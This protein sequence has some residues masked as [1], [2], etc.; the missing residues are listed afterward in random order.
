[1][2]KVDFAKFLQQFL[3]AFLESN[4]SLLNSPTFAVMLTKFID[5]LRFY[6]FLLDCDR[7]NSTSQ[8]IISEDTS[9]AP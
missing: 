9:K 4:F 6:H 3:P 8:S 7:V 2:T 5:D 1:M